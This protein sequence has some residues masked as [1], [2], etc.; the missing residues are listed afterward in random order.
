MQAMD[1]TDLIAALNRFV[2]LA[3]RAVWNARL[4][5]LK[6]GC[7]AT[8]AGRALSQR[9]ALELAIERLRQPGRNAPLTQAERRIAMLT[10]EL[11]G[12]A[13]TLNQAGRRRLNAALAECL[14]GDSTLVPLFHLARTALLHRRRGFAVSFCGL[15]D[16]ASFDL[17]IE[18]DGCKA[19]IACEVVSAETGRDVHRN[20]WSQLMDRIDPDL[21]SWLATHPG[22]Y[23]LKMTLPRGL[24]AGGE[25]AL[26]AELHQRITRMLSEQRRADYDEAAVLR[27]DPLMLAAAQANELGLIPRLRREF[28]P[29]A[30]LA[31]T[32]SS[33]AVFVMAA[34]AGREDEVAVAV[35]RRMA[36]IAPARLTGERPGILAMF[37]EDTDRLEWHAL[38]DQLRLEGEA[39]QFLTRPEARAVVAVT[40][41]S[42][43]E[44]LSEDEGDEGAELRF[45]NPGHPAAKQAA[46][47]PAVVSTGGAR[48]PAY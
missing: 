19:E 26:L 43:I 30:H 5:E 8:Y 29:E 39:R 42:R 27:L 45:R 32:A 47:A 13:E 16:E 36:E 34:R 6:R 4:A 46:L 38:R 7:S 25:C 44:L 1:H 31:V 20:A 12:L 11:A 22:R 40:C 24:K 33:G 28:G 23:L 2:A 14:R 48:A 10:A 35:H 18:R 9:H 41:A 15:E 17:L 37:I 3:G 21:Q